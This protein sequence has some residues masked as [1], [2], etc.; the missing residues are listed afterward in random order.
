V[1]DPRGTAHS[2]TIAVIGEALIDL[3]PHGAPGGYSAQPGGSPFN[4]AVGLARLGHSTS[5]MA[6]LADNSFGRILRRHALAE[7]IDLSG[8]PRA[9]EPTTLAVVSVDEHAQASYDFYQDGTADWQWTEAET[10]SPPAGTAVLHL[11]S[12]ASWTP[13]GDRHI[14]ALASRLRETDDVLISYDPNI[15][16]ALLDGPGHARKLIECTVAIAHLVKASRED[17]AWLYPGIDVGQVGDEWLALGASVVVVTDGADGAHLFQAGAPA[18][19]RPGRKAAVV[20][21]IGA[22]DAFT[23]GLLGALV[24]TGRHSPEL[25]RR[26]PPAAMAAAVDEAILV[27]A[28]TCERAGADPPTARPRSGTPPEIPLESAE[29]YFK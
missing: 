3:V 25:L 27:S 26:C 17:I 6:R 13:P 21:T 7:G 29:L 19:R 20:D 10:A 4:V 2:R 18:Q 8:A 24:R 12:I 16:P 14:N 1:A 23:S 5:L 28:L 11:G 15:R 9:H 22:G